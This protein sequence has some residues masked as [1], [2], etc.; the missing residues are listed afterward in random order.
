MKN[1]KNLALAVLLAATAVIGFA[2]FSSQSN[3]SATG[4]SYYAVKMHADWCGTCKGMKAK[5]PEITEALADSNVQ[6][7]TL[8]VTNEGRTARSLAMATKLGFADAFTAAN[9]KTGFIAVIN[10]ETGENVAKVSGKGTAAD[11][12]DGIKTAAK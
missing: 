7:I 10:S 6:M 9:G 3:A 4:L 12:A 2:S 1:I 8:D 11:I 5:M